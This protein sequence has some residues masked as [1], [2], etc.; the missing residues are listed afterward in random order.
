MKSESAPSRPHRSTR[1][2]TSTRARASRA[3]AT[4]PSS[5]AS[6]MS[7]VASRLAPRLAPST[8]RRP[9]PER[10]ARARPSAPRPSRRRARASVDLG[11]A[12]EFALLSDVRFVLC[13]PQGPANVGACARPC[14]ILDS[15]FELCDVGPFVL[16][17]DEARETLD[18]ASEGEE[19][20]PNARPRRWGRRRR[21]RRRCR[22]RRCGRRADWPLA[23]AERCETVEDALRGCT[24]VLATTARPRSGTPL[25]TAR[26]AAERVRAEAKNG[27]VAVLFERTH[28]L[29]N[30][31]CRGHTP[32]WRY[33]PR[34]RGNC[35]ERA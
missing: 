4:L 24:F 15:R 2:A 32:R 30:E 5:V 7:A 25:M 29:D 18:E 16:R 12:N 22:R 27:K 26:E 3:S 10:H 13:N 23:D 1:A 34:E 19:E 17:S 31:G 35:V 11:R 20:V 21:R 9:P 8:I 28:G 6:V 14:K 33:P